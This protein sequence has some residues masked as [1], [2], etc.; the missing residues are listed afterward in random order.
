MR[1]LEGL[2]LLE[3]NRPGE[4]AQAFSD[5]LAAAGAL[6]A[7]ADRNVAALGVRAL[8]LSGLAVLGD[9]PAQAAGAA[10]AFVRANTVTRAPGVSPTPSAC[11]RS[12]PLTTSRA[13][14]AP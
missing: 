8:A 5:A 14:S 13:C 10:E 1:L 4:S 2:A 12:S 7:L 6:L 3:L 11:S 9:D